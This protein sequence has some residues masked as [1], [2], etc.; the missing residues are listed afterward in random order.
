MTGYE[1]MYTR[2]VAGMVIAAIALLPLLLHY[3]GRR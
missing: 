2:Y 3:R 1:L